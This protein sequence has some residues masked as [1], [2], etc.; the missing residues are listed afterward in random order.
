M[1]DRSPRILVIE[2][3]PSV[4]TLLVEILGQEGYDV[5]VAQD[6]L[7]G[8]VKFRA[9]QPDLAV[10]DLVMPDVD[11][12]RFLEQVIEEEGGVPVP[13]VVITGSSDGA[14]RCRA[15]L[16]TADVFEKPFDPDELIARIRTH[17]R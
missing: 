10:L 3:D 17:L 5:R 7:A 8:L 12:V 11:G 16:G 1:T 14:A 4:S 13:V 6:G 9:G 2:D 15:L